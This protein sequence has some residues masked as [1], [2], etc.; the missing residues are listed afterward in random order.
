VKIDIPE[1]LLHLRAEITD[2]EA[3]GIEAES[4]PKKKF[5]ERMAFRMY[6]YAW[7]SPGF[8]KFGTKAARIMQK[9]VVRDGKIGKVSG[10]LAGLVPPLGNWTAWRDAPVVAPRSFRDEWREMSREL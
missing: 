4:K 5:A 3:G 10:F 2:G 1:L 6:R 9:L 7:S 8:Y